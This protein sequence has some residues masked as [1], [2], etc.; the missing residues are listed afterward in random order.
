MCILGCD[1]E[2]HGASPEDVQLP[3]VS[4]FHSAVYRFSLRVLYNGM[5]IKIISRKGKHES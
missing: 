3:E 4:C 5:C 1:A 2:N